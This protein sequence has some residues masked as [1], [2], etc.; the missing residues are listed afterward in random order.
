MS[1]FNEAR[2]ELMRRRL[3]RSGL[4]TADAGAADQTAAPALPAQPGFQPGEAR[5]WKIYRLD[6]ASVSHNI[7]LVFDIDGGRSSWEMVAATE[8]LIDHCD[9]LRS[10]IVDADGTPR[11]VPANVVGGWSTPEITWDWGTLPSESVVSGTGRPEAWTRAEIDRDAQTLTRSPFDLTAQPPLRARVYVRTDGGTAVVLVVH[12]LAVDATSWP[13]LITALLHGSWP[14]DRDMRVSAPSAAQPDVAA[15]LRHALDTWAADDVRYPLSGELPTDSPADS[16]LAPMDDGA[17][18]R[19]SVPVDPADVAALASVA[20][21]VGA[22]INTLLLT[23]CALSVY[24]VTGAADHVLVV[25]ADNRHPAHTP[26]RVGYSGNII[27]KRFRFDPDAPVRD[28]LR[29]SA[30]RIFASMEFA[31][32]DYGTI[33]TALRG[34]GGRFPVAEVMASVRDAPHRGVAIPDGLDVSCRSVFTGVANYP[35]AYAFEFDADDALHLELDHRP[36]V[37]DDAT[38]RAAADVALALIARMPSSLNVPLG[39]LISSVTP[40]RSPA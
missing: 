21:E 2:H 31:G 36:D 13:T 35:L 22:T 8:V 4:G 12:H 33:L 7:G 39:E 27:P 28:A 15:A 3:L 23:V 29:D 40:A 11:R 20:P 16:W 5:M 24:A 19:R 1:K 30:A 37:I 10:V 26:D 32:V 6:P 14:T 9:V 18:S 34:A 25:P 38:A 17:G